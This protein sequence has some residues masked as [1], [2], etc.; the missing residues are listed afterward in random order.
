VKSTEL[1]HGEVATL[2]EAF[3]EGRCGAWDWDD[4]T[5][6]MTFTDESLK[7]VQSRCARLSAEFPPQ[8][9]QHYCNAD[10]LR[11]LRQIADALKAKS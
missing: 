7:E 10:G 9:Q 2:I 3:I 11:A 5:T 1:T 6:G 8:N 4:F